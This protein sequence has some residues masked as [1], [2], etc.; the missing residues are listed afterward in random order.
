MPRFTLPFVGWVR[1]DYRPA[2]CR[3]LRAAYAPTRVAG[4]LLDVL[5][6]LRTTKL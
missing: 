6:E 3:A 2:S 4:L 1:T 5:D